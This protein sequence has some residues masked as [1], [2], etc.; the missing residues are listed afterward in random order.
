MTSAVAQVA[1][2]FNVDQRLAYACRLLR[3]AWRSGSR[4]MVTADP[5][6]LAA[7]DQALWTFATDDFIAHAG[8]VATDAER[9]HSSICLHE[10]PLPD[11]NADVLV[12]LCAEVPAGVQAY[13]RVIEIVSMDEQDRQRAR[14]RWKHYAD[15]GWDLVRHDLNAAGAT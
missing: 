4:C 8:P 6:E 13:S 11:W 7:L 15:A 10:S 5:P 1:F 9:R 12:N 3:K 14:A 2:H